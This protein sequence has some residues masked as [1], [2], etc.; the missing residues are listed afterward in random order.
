MQEYEQVQVDTGWVRMESGAA[1][2][3]DQRIDTDIEE[4]W[5][6]YQS[7]TLPKVFRTVLRWRSRGDAGQ[8]SR[9]CSTP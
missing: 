6:H 8:N 5:D 1:V 4:F 3:L 2:V 9:P 7:Q